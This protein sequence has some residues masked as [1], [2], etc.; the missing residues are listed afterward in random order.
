ML[1][2]LL[3]FLTANFGILIGNTST[4]TTA[5][6]AIASTKVILKASAYAAMTS[7]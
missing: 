6:A 1:D 3:R 7:A 4:Q 2:L 5:Y